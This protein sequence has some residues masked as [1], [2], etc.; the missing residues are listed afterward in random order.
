MASN[1]RLAVPDATDAQVRSALAT[2]CLDVEELD[3]G[4]DAPVGDRGQALSGGQVQRLALARAL[5]ARPRLLVLDEALSQLD[6]TGAREVRRRLAAM[7]DR[8]T[9]VEITHRVDLLG[10][11]A[12]VSVLD[13]GRIVQQGRVAELRAE[14]VRQEATP[15]ARLTERVDVPSSC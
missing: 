13:N 15:F 9:I 2:A 7:S 10:D 11:D 14:G 6:E 4:L 12:E 1:V 8:P 5:L 3:G